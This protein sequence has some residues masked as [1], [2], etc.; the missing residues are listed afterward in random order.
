MKNKYW[1]LVLSVLFTLIQIT[2]AAGSNAWVK[3]GVVNSRLGQQRPD[4]ALIIDHKT[5]N[6]NA[7][8]LGWLQ[9][10]RQNL[11]IYYGHTSHGSQLMDGMDGLVS[12][13]NSGGRG[14][15]LPTDTFAGLD[16]TENWIDAGYYPD[17][18][19]QTRA[20]LGS[21]VPATGRGAAHPETNVVAWAWCGQLS[22][23]GAADITSQYLQP[24]SQL[25]ADYPGITFV[26]MTGH[27]DGSGET[28]DLSVNNQQI[29]EYALQNHKVLYDF[30]DIELYDP[31]GNYYG[32]KAVNDACE[33]DSDGNGSR[34]RNWA[35][36]WQAAH[37]E[38]QDWYSC[39]CAHSQALNCNQKAYAAW[40]LWARLAG[41]GGPGLSQLAAS[42][43][44]ALPG[45]QIA[46]T[47]TLQ[48][49]ALPA[50]T[51]V[52]MTDSLPTGLTYVPGSLHA[53]QGQCQD[54]LA[55]TLTWTGALNSASVVTITFNANVTA[56]TRQ[57][58]TNTAVISASG[59]PTIQSAATLLVDPLALFLP[60]LRR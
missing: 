30:Y 60:A 22:W 23:L 19:N 56:N 2:G 20:F 15:A 29:R 55:P 35:L 26:Y 9:T 13:A 6:I 49:L 8:P 5:I 42:T 18:V 54:S 25:E 36:D 11:H 37:T 33:Y 41:W 21:P 48:N 7:I 14:L 3:N 12:F 51:S 32:N 44:S 47:V 34:D 31:D 52:T 45:Q 46:Y 59:M 4:E 28:G 38:G 17:W 16:V 39:G 1:V 53:S 24:M 57:S 43:G 40:W 50:S 10:A 58:I 27:S